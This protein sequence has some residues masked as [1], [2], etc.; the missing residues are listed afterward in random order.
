MS[1]R[2]KT[3]RVGRGPRVGPLLRLRLL[4][5]EYTHSA[6]TLSFGSVVG[7]VNPPRCHHFIIGLGYRGVDQLRLS[8]I[9]SPVSNA[10][11]VFV[12]LYCWPLS[13]PPG[14]VRMLVSLYPNGTNIISEQSRTTSKWTQPRLTKQEFSEKQFRKPGW[15]RRDLNPRPPPCQ[16]GDLPLIYEPSFAS[17][18]FPVLLLR[19]ST[20]QHRVT[21]LHAYTQSSS[22]TSR[23]LACGAYVV[24][25]R[26]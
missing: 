16:G 19:P 3:R 11:C 4:H 2:P 18:H 23:P 22:H 25:V 14:G 21:R 17:V 7:D 10:A 26:R 8:G 1:Q 13:I 6:I 24:Q 15:T 5:L 9:Q 20:R 12:C